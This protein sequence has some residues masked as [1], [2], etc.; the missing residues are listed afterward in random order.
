M[1]CGVVFTRAS[2]KKINIVLYKPWSLTVFNILQGHQIV[3]PALLIV[4]STVFTNASVWFSPLPITT[5]AFPASIQQCCTHKTLHP[6][7]R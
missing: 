4:T 5:L 1:G 3:N 6:A 2:Y 7:Q